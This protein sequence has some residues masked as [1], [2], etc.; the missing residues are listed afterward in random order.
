MFFC[1]LCGCLPATK[2]L[3]LKDSFTAHS[4]AKCPTSDKLCE[5]CAWVIPLRLNYYN[6]NTKKDVLL[7][8]RNWSWLLSENENHPKIEG[9]KVSELPSRVTIRRWLMNPPE[10]PFT[11][12]IAESG[13]KHILPWS[14]PAHSRDYFPVLF[15]L[16]LLY[17]DREKFTKTL[18][19]YEYLLSLG[20]T[21]TEINTGQYK[22]QNLLKFYSDS[23]FTE[24]ESIFLQVRCSRTFELIGYVAVSTFTSASA[25]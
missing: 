1:Y 19:D 13:Q 6:P 17:I 12:A 4:T 18:E 3:A 8:S 21:K 7:F 9:D 25:V 10:P 23:R 15:E 11:I 20:L 22:A 2:P 24:I 14:K 5:R 16:D